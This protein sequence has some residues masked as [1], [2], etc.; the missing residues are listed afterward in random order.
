[1]S[2]PT[3]TAVKWIIGLARVRIAL[4]VLVIG[5]SIAFTSPSESPMVESFRKGWVGASGYTLE[6]YGAEQAGEVTGGA[7]IP[8]ILSALMLTF[9]R[10]RKLKALQVTSLVNLIL[11][12]TQAAGLPIAIT[13]AVLAYRDSTK[14]YMMGVATSTGSTRRQPIP[15]QRALTLP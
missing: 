8:G 13:I 9:V 14:R 7:L 12:M 15:R 3:P 5:L 6:E 11:G 10:R 1:M 4:V 2:A